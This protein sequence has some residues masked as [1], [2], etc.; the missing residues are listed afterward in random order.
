VALK[1]IKVKSKNEKLKNE[2][3]QVNFL[4]QFSILWIADLMPT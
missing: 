3:L 4:V 1:K 2:K